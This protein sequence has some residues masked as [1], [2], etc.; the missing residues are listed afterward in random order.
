MMQHL[1]P[2]RWLLPTDSTDNDVGRT[3]GDYVEPEVEDGGGYRLRVRDLEFLGLDISDIEAWHGRE[4][5]LGLTKIQYEGLVDELANALRRDGIA[6]DACDVRLKGSAAKVFSGAHKPMPT[7]TDALIDLFRVLRDRVPFK[8]EISEMDLRLRR[9]WV[10]DGNYP[11]RR[12]FD[13]MYRLGVDR[14]RSDLD[15]QISSDALATRCE[16]ILVDQG[17]APSEAR[18][19]NAAYNFVRKDLVASAS[20]HLHFFSLRASDALGRHVAIAVFPSGGP[21]NVSA[22][23]PE[24]SSHFCQD[25]WVIPLSPSTVESAI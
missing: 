2:A 7:D 25:D 19:K 15:L 3:E 24:L 14:E 22:S 12:P 8:W 5:P 1:Q 10:R 16:E 11:S 18:F 9:E 17:Q 4:R 20:P 21:P 6:L 13:S 23:H